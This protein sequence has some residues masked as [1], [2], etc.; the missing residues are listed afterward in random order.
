MESVKAASEIFCPVSGTV[1]DTNSALD[2]KPGLINSSCYDEGWFRS[3]H[4]VSM[5]RS[6]FSRSLMRRDFV[7]L[8]GWIFKVELSNESDL[9]G[10]MSE[11]KYQEF[12]K[13]QEE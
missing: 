2:D 12:L 11:E 6:L 10:M 1:V 7:L 9:D 5:F 8:A 4:R 3:L 13:A